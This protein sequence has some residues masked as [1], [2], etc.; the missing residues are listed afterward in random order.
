MVLHVVTQNRV[1]DIFYARYVE[2]VEAAKRQ[3]A[4]DFGVEEIHAHS[5]RRLAEPETLFVDPASGAR[6]ML[7]DSKIWPFCFCSV[8][9]QINR[10]LCERIDWAAPITSALDTESH[11]IPDAATATTM[12]TWFIEWRE[13]C[14]L[15]IA[16]TS[17][18]INSW[19]ADKYLNVD[20]TSAT[21]RQV[22]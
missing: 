19:I 16:F 6:T 22:T 17:H 20:R 14:N 10:R 18:W 1:F 9:D 5:L 4:F 15:D 21:T 12:I 13:L 3:G 7:H 2:A 8:D 11:P